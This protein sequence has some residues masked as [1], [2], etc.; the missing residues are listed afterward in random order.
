VPFAVLNVETGRF[1]QRELL[2]FLGRKVI[3]PV[4][5]YLSIRDKL[6]LEP[7]LLLQGS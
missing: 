7:Q 6:D 5:E 2:S 3:E 1:L 4:Q